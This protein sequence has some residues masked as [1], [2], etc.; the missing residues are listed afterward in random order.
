MLSTLMTIWKITFPAN[1][2]V[3]GGESYVNDVGI[4]GAAETCRLALGMESSRVI[5]TPRSA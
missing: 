3:K 1:L 5:F 2:W 4:R